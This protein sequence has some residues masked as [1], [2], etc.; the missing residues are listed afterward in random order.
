MARAAGC[1]TASMQMHTAVR[2]KSRG[3]RGT[4]TSVPSGAVD[5]DGQEPAEC[6]GVSV[7][8]G[9]REHLFQQD[10]AR[11]VLA[12]V[13]GITTPAEQEDVP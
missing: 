5:R 10:L 6:G 12:D 13:V 7:E 8:L 1:M 2:T 9:E 4:I 11:G 3:A